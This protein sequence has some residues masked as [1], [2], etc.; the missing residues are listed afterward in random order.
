MVDKLFLSYLFIF[1]LC[2]GL[3]TG[4]SLPWNA[5]N[6]HDV[7]AALRL[8]PA[9]QL[10]PDLTSTIHIGSIQTDYSN[11]FGYFVGK[12]FAGLPFHLQ[13][14]TVPELQFKKYGIN[15]AIGLERDV[16]GYEMKMNETDLGRLYFS[17]S[18]VFNGPAYFRKLKKG[19]AVGLLTGFEVRGGI[20]DYPPI[21]SYG[22][23]RHYRP[24]DRIS[25]PEWNALAMAYFNIGLH[26]SRE[27]DLDDRSRLS[28]GLNLRYLGGM[29]HMSLENKEPIR[30][31][32]FNE[33]GDV[34]L[35][36]FRL[37]YSYTHSDGNSPFSPV[38][39]GNGIG[40]DAGIYYS[41]QLNTGLLSFVRG[42]LSLTGLG[43]LWYGQSLRNGYFDINEQTTLS[44]G[45]WDTL[46]GLDQL[47]DSFKTVVGR[48][49][50][51]IYAENR[52]KAVHLP[53]ALHFTLSTGF[54]SYGRIHYYF[55]IP[56]A[57]WSPDA[58]QIGMVPELTF[59]KIN[60]LV[61]FSYNEWTGFRLGAGLNLDFL[62]FGTDDVRS[63]FKRD[64]LQ[65]GSLYFGVN[66]RTKAQSVKKKAVF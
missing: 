35:S 37:D 40:G 11:N 50:A 20:N 23:Y 7:I 6:G 53:G 24:G 33:D 54:R 60:V 36:N 12:S 39:K 56:V 15:P 30:D 43:R 65:S 59:D 4:Q 32:I 8:N 25:V 29:F 61:P 1:L 66:L 46:T 3:M 19:Y 63:F 34:V 21:L 28:A 62:T 31:Y 10:H 17:T 13:E 48:R 38:V 22:P 2:H 16:R 49:P 42:G 41:R 44:F 18:M 14:I 52:G 26:L 64:R 27:I 58:M 55:S 9:T 45:K 47:V 57:R 51:N 5:L